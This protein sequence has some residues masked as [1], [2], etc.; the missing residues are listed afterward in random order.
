MITWIIGAG[1]LLGSAVTRQNRDDTYR[2]GPVPWHDPEAAALCLEQQAR[3]LPGATGDS[4][5]RVIWA[6]GAATT[7]SLRQESLSELGPL[8]GLLTGLCGALPTGPGSFF[9]TSSAGGVFAGSEHPPFT[10]KTPPAPLSPYGELK[11]A[12]EQLVAETV[13]AVTSTVI[14]RMSNLYGPGQNLDK[15]QGLIS[16][17]ALASITQEPLNVFVS[18][19]TMRDYL[20][21]DD[22][23]RVVLDLTSNPSQAPGVTTHVLATGRGT[24]IGQLIRTMN[25]ITKRRVP[26]ALGTH[27]SAQA[28]ALDLRLEP[29]SPLRQITTL[30]AGMKAVHD[31]LLERVRASALV[32]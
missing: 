19:G 9:L 11:L 31:D 28:Q 15:L 18:L 26:V 2:P 29:S 14:G 27:P 5:W 3:D 8:R 10:A 22:A 17:L 30:P 25:E 12:Q 21:V 20:Y 16:R 7:S 32:R 13:G 1:G 6:A 4:P 23:A 24:T